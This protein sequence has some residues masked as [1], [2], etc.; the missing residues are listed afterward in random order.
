MEKGLVGRVQNVESKERFVQSQI[1]YSGIKES[2]KKASENKGY[3]LFVEQYLEPPVFKGDMQ[4]LTIPSAC[5]FK[6]IPLL[7]DW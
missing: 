3:R 2:S 1:A 4:M 6:G 7:D 5:T